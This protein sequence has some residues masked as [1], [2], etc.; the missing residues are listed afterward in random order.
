MRRARVPQ[1]AIRIVLITSIA[2]AVAIVWGHGQ[3]ILRVPQ[4][5]PT[6]EEAVAAAPSGATIQIAEGTYRVQLTIDKNLTLEGLRDTVT[7]RANNPIEPIVRVQGSANVTLR[8]LILDDGTRSLIVQESAVVTLENVQAQDATLAGVLVQDRG[9]LRCMN[10]KIVGNHGRA[11]VTAQDQAQLTLDKCTVQGNDSEGVL[12]MGQ[13]RLEARQSL[14]ERNRGA[15]L[16]LSDDAQAL[17]VSARF[18]TNEG[19]GIRLHGHARLSVRQSEFFSNKHSIEVQDAAHL[20]AIQV[21]FRA[22]VQGI[23]LRDQATALIRECEF[24]EGEGIIISS[25]GPAIT[26][27]SNLFRKGREAVTINSPSLETQVFLR[28]NAFED[29]FLSAVEITSDATITIE[30]NRFERNFSAIEGK[31]AHHLI[32]RSNEFF[33]NY[34]AVGLAG[35]QIVVEDNLFEGNWVG[36]AAGVDDRRGAG[37]LIQRNRLLATESVAMAIGGASRGTLTNNYIGEVSELGIVILDEVNITLTENTLRQGKRHGVVLSGTAQASLQGNR[38]SDFRGCALYVGP[39]AKLTDERANSFAGNQG[40]DRCGRVGNSWQ[41]QVEKAQPGSVLE[42]PPGVYF[43]SLWINKPI[44]IRSSGAVFRGNG[45]DAVISVTGD[46]QVRLEG[47]TLQEGRA[48]IIAAGVHPSWFSDFLA[49]RGQQQ[50]ILK[51]IKVLDNKGI[52]LGADFGVTEFIIEETEVRDNGSYGIRFH[53]STL[54]LIESTIAGHETGLFLDMFG[55]EGRPTA[56][57][58]KTSFANNQLGIEVEGTGDDITLEASQISGGALGMLIG[59]PLPR[60]SRE[61]PSRL[62]IVQTLVRD[63]RKER[64]TS[65]SLALLSIAGEFV[66]SGMAIFSGVE[67]TLLDNEIAE[68]GLA[69]IVIGVGGAAVLQGNRIIANGQYGLALQIAGC[70]QGLFVPP[71]FEGRIEGKQNTVP[72]PGEPHANLKGAFCPKELEF[73]K[74]E[75]GGSYP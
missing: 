74:T 31:F 52:G 33:D 19:L 37:L 47:L 42:I 64:G 11:G 16:V 40:G 28:G 3:V 10:S 2:L 20:E 45:I 56:S 23:E 24:A 25:S 69:G 63:H 1:K 67:A 35:S 30:H 14:F 73:L 18:T 54:R 49:E 29:R 8:R 15:A 5:F 53:G 41:E 32:V 27:E 50:L 12:V 61:Q 57:I 17:V 34:R 6:I 68:N 38:M 72:S 36:I 13:A 48:G 9:Q 43:E 51:N 70:M 22:E 71:R 59:S 26:I 66:G 4:D 39:K 44:E 46:A 58:S 60:S 75:Q 55:R 62:H 21:R 65:F 7:L